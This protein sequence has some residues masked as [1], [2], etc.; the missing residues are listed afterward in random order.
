MIKLVN[1]T[2]TFRTGEA[3][4]SDV[5]LRIEKGEFVFI[6]GS[7][8][9]GKTTFFRLLTRE[10]LPSQ[11][12]ILVHEWDITKLPNRKVPHLRRQIGM[13]FQDLKLLTDRTIYENVILPLEMARMDGKTARQKV[14]DVLEQ[15]GIAEHKDKFPIQLSGGELQRAAIAR[16]LVFSPE[17]II[18]DE[19][20]G[21]LDTANSWGIVKLLQ[22][23][24][25]HGT[26][27]L[28]AT[29]NVEV[30]NNLG[31]RVV[32]LEKGKIIKDDK[33]HEHKKAEHTEKK[34]HESH[35]KHDEHK[36]KKHEEG[37]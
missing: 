7:S 11:G 33:P 6:M 18:A 17:I 1:V 14:Y 34:E 23:I 19:P 27:V 8:G 2:K 31:K 12:T 36:E 32:T 5:S 10:M 24:N 15:V 13:I 29:H 22:D 26:T 16:A 21:N 28:M 3:A 30:V 25:S 35:K 20:T 9:S 37:S 4:L